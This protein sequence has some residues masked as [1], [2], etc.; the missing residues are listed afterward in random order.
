MQVFLKRNGRQLF[1]AFVMALGLVFLQQLAV[2]SSLKIFVLGAALLA[3][4]LL[5]ELYTNYFFAERLLKQLD[6]PGPESYSKSVQAVYHLLLPLLLYFSLVGFVYTNNRL[7]LGWLYFCWGFALFALLFINIRAY[8]ED[9]FKL[10]ESTH[11]IYDLIK[12]FVYFSF[13]N[14]ILNLAQAF[15]FSFFVIVGVIFAGASLLTLL[16]LIRRRHYSEQNLALIILAGLVLGYLTAVL[17]GSFAGKTLLLAFYSTI[18]F[19]LFNA[20]L[21][22]EIERTLNLSLVFE[23]LLVAAICLSVILLIP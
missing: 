6:L 21:H 9:K 18:V 17:L 12:I 5:L 22:H 13:T 19:Y 16:V 3:L 14:A 8:Y 7:D 23:Y 20:V 10:E 11:L 2:V 4:V 15:G 1:Y